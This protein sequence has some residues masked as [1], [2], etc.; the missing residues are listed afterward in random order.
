MSNSD[1]KDDRM[2]GGGKEGSEHKTGTGTDRQTGAG[3]KPAGQQQQQ[4]G[5]GGQQGGQNP[6][7]GTQQGGG[8]GS[9]KSSD[10]MSKDPGQKGRTDR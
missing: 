2:S 10:D 7:R 5:S 4:P 3:G 9:G 6:N 1:V 8:S